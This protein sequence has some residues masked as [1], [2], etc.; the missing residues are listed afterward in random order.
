MGDL[1][2]RQRGR[3]HLLLAAEDVR[4]SHGGENRV[5]LC[6]LRGHLHRGG[7][8]HCDQ[9]GLGHDPHHNRRHHRAGVRPPP[10][11]AAWRLPL[12]KPQAHPETNPLIINA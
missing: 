7:L 3:G 6:L 5:R 9:A 1:A 12:G 4:G 10:A 2:P 11:V 8:L